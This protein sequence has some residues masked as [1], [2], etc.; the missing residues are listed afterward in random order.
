MKHL[1]YYQVKAQTHFELG[2]K[3]AQLFKGPSLALYSSLLLKIVALKPEKEDVKL[4]LE[5]TEKYFPQYIEEIK[6]YAHGLGVDFESYWLT[7]LL[8]ELDIYPEKCTSCFS[9]DGMIV[10]HNED[11]FPYF[12]NTIAI[13]DKTLGNSNTFELYYY[14]SIGGTACGINSNGYV[15]TINTLDHID[16]QIGVPR[17]IISRWLSETTNPEADFKKLQSIKRSIGYS[18]TFCNLKGD[19]TNIECSGTKSTLV[20]PELPFVHTNHY[21]TSLSQYEDVVVGGNSKDRY[22][23]AKKQIVTVK[24]AQDMMKLL[25]YIS[26]LPSNKN[27]ECNTIARM[28]FDLKN[29]SVWCWLAKEH[30]KGW[31]EYPLNFI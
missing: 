13:L 15:Q 10:G 23:E 11:F 8:E 19:V 6:G 26:C 17:N 21:L 20:N 16:K 29:K 7:F 5:T 4:Y 24:T 27:R 1:H 18:H 3:L 28:V 12:E 14:N 9:S 22:T 31:I 30:S 25:E 2:N